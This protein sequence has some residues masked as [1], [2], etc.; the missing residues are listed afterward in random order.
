MFWL[1]QF[2]PLKQIKEF[3]PWQRK[4]ELHCKTNLCY[5]I[6]DL[7]FDPKTL[8][9]GDDRELWNNQSDQVKLMFNTYLK[10]PLANQPMTKTTKMTTPKNEK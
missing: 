6:V 8:T 1:L 2:A 3:F 4:F 9:D 10:T 7:S 5:R